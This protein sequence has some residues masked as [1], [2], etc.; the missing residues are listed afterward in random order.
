MGSIF[1]ELLSGLDCCERECERILSFRGHIKIKPKKQKS[2]C[3]KKHKPQ[4]KELICEC[5][6]EQK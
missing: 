2:S 5:E 6:C 1:S 3:F 4:N